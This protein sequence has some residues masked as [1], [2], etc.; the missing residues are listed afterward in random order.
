[1]RLYLLYES[2]AG[3]SIFKRKKFKET[4]TVENVISLYK[5]KEKFMKK[6]KLHGF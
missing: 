3:L 4:L 2:A 6:F 5:N 1:M